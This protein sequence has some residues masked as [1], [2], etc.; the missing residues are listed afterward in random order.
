MQPRNARH[1]TLAATPSPFVTL[2]FE[3]HW[4][5]ESETTAARVTNDSS[6]EPVASCTPLAGSIV[7]AVGRLL[8]NIPQVQ[9]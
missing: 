6:N 8:V 2:H 1:R 9:H 3:L 5:A 7:H 4:R